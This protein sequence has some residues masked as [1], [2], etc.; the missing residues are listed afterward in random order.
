MNE[1]RNRGGSAGGLRGPGRALLQHVRV[2]GNR[3][4]GLPAV[5]VERQLRRRD[6]L[7]LS[8]SNLGGLADGPAT[9]AGAAHASDFERMMAAAGVLISDEHDIA[10]REIV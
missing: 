7:D 8:G 10:R 6:R 1:R 4:N 3:K 9:R 2:R 5:R